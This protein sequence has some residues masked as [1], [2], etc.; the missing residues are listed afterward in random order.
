MTTY[1]DSVVNLAAIGTLTDL[2]T[3]TN[4]FVL[5]HLSS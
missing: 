3:D 4:S 5:M 2:K 1:L